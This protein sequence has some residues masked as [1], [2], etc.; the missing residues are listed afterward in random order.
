VDRAA[1]N[2]AYSVSARQ[3]PLSALELE[4]ELIFDGRFTADGHAYMRVTPLSQGGSYT[5]EDRLLAA[6]GMLDVGV[7]ERI[8]IIGGARVERSELDLVAQATIG[9]DQYPVQPRYTDV[10]PSLAVNFKLTEAQNLRVSAAQTLARPEYRELAHVL[11]REVL[12]GENVRGNPDLKR[13]LIQNADVRWEWYP[14]AGEVLSIA[15]FAKQFQDPIER[16]YRATS[17]TSLVTFV[18]ADEARNL[19]V[20]LEL[21]K[22]LGFFAESLESLTFFTNATLMR[23]RIQIAQSASSQTNTQRAMVGQAPYVLNAGLTLAPETSRSSATLLYNVTGKRILSAGEVPLPDMYEQ[24]RH[25][26]DLA[27]RTGLFPGVSLKLDAKN[28]LDAPY[29]VTQG[30]VVRETYRSGRSYSVGLSW[31]R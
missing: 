23:S 22:R 7:S 2:T 5:A 12:G 11:Y 15:L 3:L 8:R 19:G 17:G 26:L 29:E 10:L 27:L 14:N 25:M 6:Y 4:P 20:E 9:P 1:T 24:S 31:Q 30:A 21:R 28:L 18:N 13:T 16:V